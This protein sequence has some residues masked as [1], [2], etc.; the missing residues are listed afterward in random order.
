M[1][2]GALREPETSRL[3][4]LVASYALEDRV[5]FLGEFRDISLLLSVASVFVSASHREGFSL[6]TVE[7]MASRVPVVV[8]DSG[9]PAEIVEQ[10]RCGLVVPIQNAVALSDVI[11]T[12]LIESDRTSDRVSK[13]Y[14]RAQTEYTPK[15]MCARYL[16][17]YQSLLNRR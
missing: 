1:I 14:A 9:G 15:I 11:H 7:A 2:A 6:T 5:I 12:T 10:G 16:D 8:T 4:S 13:G 17:L 3:K